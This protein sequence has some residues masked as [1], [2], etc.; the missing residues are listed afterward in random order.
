MIYGFDWS[1]CLGKMS[2][3]IK[4]INIHVRVYSPNVGVDKCIGF[5]LFQHNWLA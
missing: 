4:D 3:N 1:N 5:N 2:L